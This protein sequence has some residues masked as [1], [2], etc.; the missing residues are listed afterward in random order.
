[1]KQQ[2]PPQRGLAPI[3]GL[4]FAPT[5]PVAN[6]QFHLFPAI[7]VK[8][9][10]GGT[11]DFIIKPPQ[12]YVA[13]LRLAQCN[14]QNADAVSQQATVSILWQ[15]LTLFF[16]T[17]FINAVTGALANWSQASPINDQP[18]AVPTVVQGGLPELWFPSD[19]TVKLGVTGP[20]VSNI[21][22]PVLIYEIRPH[23]AFY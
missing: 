1:M 19:F 22:E 2:L 18:G 17:T 10:V 7:L 21:L 8:S 23:N 14:A 13:C 16:P 5:A 3:A 15:S 12:G 4:P 11:S 6:P 20:A 9:T